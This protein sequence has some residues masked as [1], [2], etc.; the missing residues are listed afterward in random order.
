MEKPG[1]Y[2]LG[3]GHGAVQN[4]GRTLPLVIAKLL[5]NLQRQ[6]ISGWGLPSQLP[7]LTLDSTWP[8]HSC[9][10]ANWV[11]HQ[12]AQEKTLHSGLM[13]TSLGQGAG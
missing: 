1:A 12:E 10:A 7:R 13:K 5:V 9:R 11:I 8:A 4:R 2:V 3:E 6:P